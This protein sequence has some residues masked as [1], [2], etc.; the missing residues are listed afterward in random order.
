MDQPRRILIDGTMA[1]GGGGF[2]YLVNVLPQLAR[3]APERCFRVLLRNPLL[4]DSLPAH[5]NLEVELLEPDAGLTKRL[6]F[7]YLNIPRIAREWGADLCFSAGEASPLRAPCPTIAA[8][9]NPNIYTDLGQEW[10]LLQKLRFAALRGISL[11]SSWCCERILFVSQDSAEWIGDSLRTSRAKR[12][13]IHHGIDSESWQTGSERPP[14]MLPYILSV[15]S[16][17]RYK[18]FVR[19]IEAYSELAARNRNCPDLLIIGDD[20]DPEYSAKMQ[21]AREKSGDCAENI[22][23]LGSIPYADIQSYYA[24]AEIFVFPSYLETFGHPLLE[25]MASGLPT[26]AADIPV[27]REIGGDAVLY[28]DPHS[29]P[30]LAKAM[31]QALFTRGL[32]EA[33]A[34]RG[35]ERV[36]EFTWEHTATRLLS[37]FSEVCAEQ[38]AR[39]WSRPVPQT[40]MPSPVVLAE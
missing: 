30:A 27:F 33:L 34:K 32:A 3:L 20:Q 6:R 24:S 12:Y 2:T 23:I 37:L 17:Y 36:R 14:H 10:S 18:N 7:T 15:S 29:A 31:E 11:L 8:F 16:I 38:E 5:P 19:L 35:R 40:G 13:S 9:R 39:S 4:A 28:A 26:V 22:H 1:R 21:A 25:A